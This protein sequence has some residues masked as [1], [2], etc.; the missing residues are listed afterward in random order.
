MAHLVHLVKKAIMSEAIEMGSLSKDDQAK[1][2]A[3]RASLG[4]YPK[5]SVTA[6]I[7]AIRPAYGELSESQW[8]ENP[9]FAIEVLL[10]KRG[11][12]PYEGCW[13]LPGGFIRPTESVEEGA[14]RELHEET[15]LEAHPLIPIGV[16]SDPGRDMRA[17]IISNAFVSVYRRGE[18]VNVKGC[19]DAAAAKW[20][21]VENPVI[22]GGKFNLPFYEDGKNVFS[23]RG[24][25]VHEDLCGGHIV[26]VEENTLA[27]DHA[28]IIATAFMRL[29][30]FDLKRL[31]FFFLPDEFS[32]TNYIDV[33]QYLTR[34]SIDQSNIPN[35]R[36]QLTAT[37]TPF[38]VPIEGKFE[39]E[40]KGH[41]KAQLYRRNIEG[42][43]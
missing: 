11:M 21:R 13:A 34:N 27:F 3:Y 1:V 15:S 23:L 32:L 19:D 7:I 24:E 41:V 17:W 16:F 5:P 31:A 2:E 39:D 29:L 10:I 4:K 9:K 43:I 28:K 30:A 18:G 36:R 14:R 8:R 37:K 20:F 12:W 35:F 40:G 26:S 25:C 38:L 33:Y 42:G 6:D 22:A